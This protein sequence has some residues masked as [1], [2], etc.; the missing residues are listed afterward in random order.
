MCHSAVRVSLLPQPAITGT[1]PAACSTHQP[2]TRWMLIVVER[3]GLAGGAARDERRRALLDLPVDQPA[4][5]GLIQ[6]S[7]AKRSRQ[8]RNRAS[9][10]CVAPAIA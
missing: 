8:S 7:V 5:C 2:I 9:E 10:H 6:R 1:R 4:E 3:R